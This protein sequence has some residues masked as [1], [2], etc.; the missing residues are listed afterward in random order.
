MIPLSLTE[1]LRWFWNIALFV[2]KSIIE[3]SIF[4]VANCPIVFSEPVVNLWFIC[5]FGQGFFN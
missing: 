5:V 1:L 4:R 3:R 2:G